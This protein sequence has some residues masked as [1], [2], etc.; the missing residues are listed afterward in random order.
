MRGSRISGKKRC[1]EELSEAPDELEEGV[2]SHRLVSGFRV[3]LPAKMLT[4]KLFS[5]TK[6]VLTF[7][8]NPL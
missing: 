1:W 2:G 6:N 5:N 7:K 8:A 3:L 4:D